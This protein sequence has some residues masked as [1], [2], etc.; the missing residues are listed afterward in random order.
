MAVNLYP[1]IILSYIFL[2]IEKQ[3][4][5]LIGCKLSHYR[6]LVSHDILVINIY[7]V[8]AKLRVVS[9]V[10]FYQYFTHFHP[11]EIAAEKLVQRTN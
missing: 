10:K 3:F 6:V 9:L 8:T 7:Q 2:Y 1:L 4:L 5:F 11:L